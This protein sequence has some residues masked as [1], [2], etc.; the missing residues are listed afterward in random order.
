MADKAKKARFKPAAKAAAKAD[1]K[2]R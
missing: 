2:R 1:G